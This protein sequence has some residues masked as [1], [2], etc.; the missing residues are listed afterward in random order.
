MQEFYLGRVIESKNI[1]FIVSFHCPCLS[2]YPF[3]L[4]RF[5]S[6][7]LVIFI[8]VEEGETPAKDR[9]ARE[10]KVIMN[11]ILQKLLHSFL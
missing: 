7:I 1:L 3:S 8:D 6:I 10:Y 9:I 11:D 2:S 5:S 4:K